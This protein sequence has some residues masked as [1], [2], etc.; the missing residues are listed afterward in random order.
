METLQENVYLLYQ[1]DVD[2]KLI[3]QINDTSE[4]K[5][6]LTDRIRMIAAIATV[7]RKEANQ[8]GHVYLLEDD[9]IDAT[10]KNL[11]I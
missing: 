4:H 2:L 3:D 8:N 5:I 1:A 7:L 10:K 11:R 6:E 9:L